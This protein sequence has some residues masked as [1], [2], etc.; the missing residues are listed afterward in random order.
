MDVDFYKRGA[1]GTPPAEPSYILSF[2]RDLGRDYRIL[3]EAMDGLGRDLKIVTLPYL[4]EG[5]DVEKPWI[6]VQ[7][8]VTYTELFSLYAGARAVVV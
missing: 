8:R 3:V 5:V 1:I 4:L 6:Q 2:G 7:Q